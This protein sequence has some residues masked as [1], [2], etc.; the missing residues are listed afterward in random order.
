MRSL[1]VSTCT[2]TYKRASCFASGMLLAQDWCWLFV[3]TLS[4]TY[5]MMQAELWW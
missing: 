5:S 1:K 4:F 3:P 2:F